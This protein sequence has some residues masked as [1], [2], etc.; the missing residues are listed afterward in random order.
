MIVATERVGL[1]NR[2]DFVV[3][4]TGGIGAGKSAVADFLREEYGVRIID[5]DN[6]CRDLL[7]LHARGWLALKKHFGNEFIQ[8]DGLIDR[9]RLRSA[10]FEDKNLRQKIDGVLHPMVREEIT[11]MVHYFAAHCGYRKLIVEVPL[12]FEAHWEHDF[13]KI[14][15]VYA[16]KDQCR[17]RLIRRDRVSPQEAAMTIDSQWPLADKALRADHVIDNSKIYVR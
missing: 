12:L 4:L 9:R 16:G 14:V 5:A 13:A 1:E 15:V 2:R 3:G 6:V 17:E 11:S 7:R 10:L 8:P